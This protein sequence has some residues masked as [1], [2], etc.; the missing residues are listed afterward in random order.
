MILRVGVAL[1]L[2]VAAWA[3]EAWAGPREDAAEIA[4][5]FRDGDHEAVRKP[6][7]H[8]WI[9]AD[10]LCAQG[11]FDAAE[12][13]AGEN[14]ELTAYVRALR[15]RGDDKKERQLLD[16]LG[17]VR[18]PKALLAAAK[19]PERLD[20]VVR[21]RLV[22]ARA[23]AWS[24]LRKH[25]ESSRDFRAVGDAA[26]ALG[27]LRRAAQGYVQA[28]LQAWFGGNPTLAL[29]NWDLRH[30]IV[31]ALKDK[32]LIVD[33]CIKRG[34][35][36]RALG[37]YDESLASY[38]I[39]LKNAKELGRRLD[40][41]RILDNVGSVHHAR[42]DYDKALAVWREAANIKRELKDRRGLSLTVGNL[43][44]LLTDRGR[45]DE[46]LVRL[47]EARDLARETGDVR[48]VAR[49]TLNIG[50]V[51]LGRH[52]YI[53]A[54]ADFQTA[55]A[56]HQKDPAGRSG[57]AQ[58]L[59]AMANVHRW[60]AEYEQALALLDRA[61]A[62]F[63]AMQDPHNEAHAL[64]SIGRIH[65]SLGHPAKALDYGHRGLAIAE[66]I[67][68]GSLVARA[69]LDLGT[70]CVDVGRFEDAKR[71]FRKALRLGEKQ[72]DPEG[73]V[74]ALHNLGVVAQRQQR[75]DD[76]QETYERILEV[77]PDPVLGPV[78]TY[79]ALGKVHALRGE[80]ERAIALLRKALAHAKANDLWRPQPPLKLDLVQSLHRLGKNAEALTLAGAA[81]ADLEA[82]GDR[83]GLAFAH[84]A[85]AQLHYASGRD[86]AAITAAARSV[87][88]V[89]AVAGGLGEQ[90][91]AGARER[92]AGAFE[93]GILAAHRAGDVEMLCHFLEGSKAQLLQEALRT[94]ETLQEAL[95]PKALVRK[96]AAARG[97]EARS[98]DAYDRARDMRKRSAIRA[99]RKAVTVAQANV[100]AAVAAIQRDAKAVAA[101]MHP[102]PASLETLQGY[103][104][105]DAA[106]VLYGVTEQTVV[107]LVIEQDA[108]RAVS[109][110]AT[111]KIREALVEFSVGSGR[112]RADPARPDP[113][114]S[115]KVG[116]G[117]GARSLAALRH[118][119]VTPLKLAGKKRILVA[120]AGQLGYAPFAAL[121]P[122]QDVVCVPSGTAYGMLREQSKRR[123]TGV[124]AVGDPDYSGTKLAALPATRGE[125]EAIGTVKLLGAG[126][127]PDAVRGALAKQKRW[128]AVHL[129]CHGIIDVERPMLSRLV[130]TGGALR[131]L[132]IYRMK[133]PA[134]L[135]VLSACETGKGRVYRTEG[136]VG[137]TRAFMTAGAPRVI[138]SLWKVDDEATRILMVKFYE[139]WKK[140]PTATALRLAQEHVAK[141]PAWRHPRFWAAW[142]LWGVP[143]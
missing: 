94:R 126:A 64:G 21:I 92:F 4:A 84:A 35:A 82:S 19:A 62:E 117:D 48:G 69:A 118:L 103:L 121:F 56:L 47:V 104:E 49:H 138:V 109:L 137:L 59:G 66:R 108:T 22:Q 112:G 88:E 9:V 127:R 141:Q 51:R 55:L 131:T 29:E 40:R 70:V 122:G 119:V 26:R 13:F 38:A 5:K 1:S 135:A 27:W 15:K 102:E 68:A 52:D 142:Q 32:A 91:G 42:A 98:R 24:R 123:G 81:I 116:A 16:S 93:F 11:A 78:E 43:G 20:T 140:H 37:R 61:L 25:K 71:H 87:R 76:A 41:A 130:L 99:A 132:D 17:A 113:R 31:R 30:G 107:A 86:A 2:V 89:A 139:L 115:E 44:L 53:R 136:I 143:E 75:Y 10:F 72:K 34:V 58:C 101:I 8:P 95:V 36:L 111:A 63:V 134:D 110:G 54:L 120:P 133:V 3:V 23:T 6:R 105:P 45:L 14:P 106:L 128:R 33:T 67:G 100:V 97:E 96:L 73:V 129:A 12:E 60:M 46:A 28:G 77:D 124:L 50:N 39:A 65:Q 80:D 79:R 57:A 85:L 18:D 7:P 83:D 90:G 74:V 114:E 125:V